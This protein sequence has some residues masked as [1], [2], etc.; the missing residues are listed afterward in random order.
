MMEEADLAID[1]YHFGGCN[2]ISD[3][4]FLRLPTVTWDGFKWYARIGSQM[5][6]LVGVQDCIA[7]TEEQYLQIIDKLI[8][9]DAAREDVRQRILKAD[10]DNTIYSTDEAKYF[11][12][13]VDYV[14]ANH[15][16]LKQDKDRPAI[17]IPRR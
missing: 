1:S 15:D 12:D 2:T 5:L 6:R 16:K 13:A 9:D 11:A 17:C 10:L 8:H 14:I 7:E 3:N 4:M